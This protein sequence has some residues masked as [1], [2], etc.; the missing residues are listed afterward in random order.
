MEENKNINDPKVNETVKVEN[1]DNATIQNTNDFTDKLE[2]KII[3]E[4]PVEQQKGIFWIFLFFGILIAVVIGLPYIT[5][6]LEAKKNVPEQPQ[7]VVEN[8]TSENETE[9]IPTVIYREIDLNTTFGVDELRFTE[10]SK[11]IVDD[12]Y[13]LKMKITNNGSK[14]D[15]VEPKYFIELFTQDK[16]LVER[17]KL[18]NDITIENNQSVSISLLISEEAYNNASLLIVQTKQIEDYPEVEISKNVDDKKLLVCTNKY[19]TISY[20]FSQDN[21]LVEINDIYNYSMTIG[22]EEKY[23][24]E[25]NIYQNRV[26]SLSN[27]EGVTSSIVDTDSSFTV[28]TVIDLEKADISKLNSFYYFAKDTEAKTVKFEMESMR[29]TCE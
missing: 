2:P 20:Y 21:K 27:N 17:V 18:V 6:Y 28:N 25:L 12:E 10:L 5:D 8:V 29:Y 23:N 3:G 26:A 15:F 22:Q 19:N 1:K 14:Y 13:Y 7:E 24:E 16:T 9:E 4:L 11:E